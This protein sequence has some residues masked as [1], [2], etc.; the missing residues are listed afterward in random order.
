[1]GEKAD[2]PAEP[3]DALTRMSTAQFRE[4]RATTASAAVEPLDKVP[5]KSSPMN[6]ATTDDVTLDMTDEQT[7]S[8]PT[9]ERAKHEEE[10]PGGGSK[11]GIM[12][13]V[14]AA[15]A[16]VAVIVVVMAGGGGDAGRREASHAD[17]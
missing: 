8:L 13:A 9:G 3:G 14:V 16:V 1:M 4:L 17:L 11:R 15:I 12:A 10:Q 7:P 5:P 6:P 2:T